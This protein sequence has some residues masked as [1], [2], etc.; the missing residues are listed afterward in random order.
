MQLVGHAKFSGASGVMMHGLHTVSVDDQITK[1][2]TAITA[3]IG[4]LCIVF[5]FFSPL[6]LRIP[7]E[8]YHTV[9]HIAQFFLASF[10]H[11]SHNESCMK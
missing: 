2:A 7:Q 8:G 1:M 4:I 10:A 9:A 3:I 5:I 6:T 11:Q